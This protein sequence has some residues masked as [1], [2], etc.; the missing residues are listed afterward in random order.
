MSYAAWVGKEEYD[1]ACSKLY[2][3]YG[4]KPKYTGSV[5]RQLQQVKHANDPTQKGHN[6]YAG[7]QD[8]SSEAR[9]FLN[10]LQ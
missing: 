8:K 10:S 3:P 2:T 5:R 6:P 7:P 9:K 4:E 1:E